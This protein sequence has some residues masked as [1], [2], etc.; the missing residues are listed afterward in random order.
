MTTNQ[1][2]LALELGQ[3]VQICPIDDRHG[4]FLATVAEIKKQDKSGCT[5]FADL[6]QP[7][8]SFGDKVVLCTDQVAFPDSPIK[9]INLE[10]Y[11][12]ALG[13]GK[14]WYGVP[15]TVAAA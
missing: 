13:H 3:V 8:G 11:E 14:V 4:P 12:G 2:L 9:C 15:A 10:G 6:Q 1:T 5:I 7:H